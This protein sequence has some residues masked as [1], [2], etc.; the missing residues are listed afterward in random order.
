MYNEPNEWFKIATN[1]RKVRSDVALHC[2]VNGIKYNLADDGI[3]PPAVFYFTTYKK[4]L[5][6][7]NLVGI[8]RK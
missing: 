8:R 4:N 5:D 7:L 6:I 2:F 1:D 3:Q